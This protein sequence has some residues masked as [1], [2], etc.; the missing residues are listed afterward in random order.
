MNQT[1]NNIL[2]DSYYNSARLVNLSIFQL[3]VFKYFPPGRLQVLSHLPSASEILRVIGASAAQLCFFTLT[4]RHTRQ[5][6]D[7]KIAQ[8]L[9]QDSVCDVVSGEIPEFFMGIYSASWENHGTKSKWWIFQQATIDYWRVVFIPWIC[10]QKFSWEKP[11]SEP[12]FADRERWSGRTE[13][14][15]GAGTLW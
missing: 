9:L 13:R 5:L 1:Y 15:S 6:H 3:G 10:R 8:R 12:W 14:G 2:A 11:W 7:V 4:L